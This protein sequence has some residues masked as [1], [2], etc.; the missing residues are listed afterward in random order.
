MDVR[1]VFPTFSSPPAQYDQRYLQDLVRALDALVRV[2][3]APGEGRQTTIV[4]TDLQS[5]D[6]GLEPG[7]IFEVNGALRVSVV[8]SPYVAG[9]SSTGAVGSVTVTT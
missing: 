8:Y 3:K 9:V 5:N 7:T 6:Y 2:V 4:L 1:L